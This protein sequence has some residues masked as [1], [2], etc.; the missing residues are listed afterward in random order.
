MN[1]SARRRVCILGGGLGGLATAYYLTNSHDWRDKFE[2]VTVHQ[3]GWRLGGKCA[4]SRNPDACNRIEEHGIHLFGGFY[5]NAFDIMRGVYA[6]L[7]R[8]PGAPLSSID[9]AFLP[10]DSLS[11]WEYVDTAWDQWA[12]L[13]GRNRHKPWDG[14]GAVTPGQLLAGAFRGFIAMALTSLEQVE[15]DILGRFGL[16]VRLQRN[17]EKQAQKIIAHFEAAHSPKDLLPALRRIHRLEAWIE[18]S[19]KGAIDKSE[20]WRRTFIMLDYML[21]LFSGFIADNVWEQGFD[22]L[23]DEDFKDWLKRHG[24]SELTL[25][26]PVPVMTPNVLFAYENGDPSRPPTMGAGGFLHWSFLSFN[27]LGSYAWMFAAGTGETIIAPLY[28]VLKK[29]GV[30]FEFFNKVESISLDNSKTEI[31]SVDIG[32]QATLAPGVKTYDPLTIDPK[33]GLIGWPAKPHYGQLAQ[34]ETLRQRAADGEPVNLESYW[35]DWKPVEQKT[36]VRGED[37]DELVLAISIGAFPYICRELIDASDKWKTMVA[38]LPA[39]QTQSFQIWLRKPMSDLACDVP[40]AADDIFIGSSYVDPT[41]AFADMSRLIEHEGWPE[42]NKPASILYFCGAM[43][44]EADPPPFS[45]HDYPI[46]Q[47]ARVKWQAA[48][49]LQSMASPLIPGGTVHKGHPVLGSKTGLD[50]NLLVCP[51]DPACTTPF[52]RIGQ[53]FFRANVDPTERYVL[54]L[55][56]STRHRLAPGEAGFAYLV[57]AGDWT[58]NGL[59]VG[60][61]EATA[62]S[63]KLAAKALGAQVEDII[64]FNFW[65]SQAAGA[66]QR[67]ADK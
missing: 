34:G 58:N 18:T 27:D 40:T 32:I 2:S 44:E 23:D 12:L 41:S 22:A 20:H 62:I 61:V 66:G 29:R 39:I 1:P 60:C 47:D 42:E 5:Y 31:Q 11:I 28:E 36:L 19:F 53:Q 7:D 16:K 54:S 17:V 38:A 46:R 6:E 45:D 59:N 26:S 9:T 50:F 56:K 43:A 49:F 55:P 30:K 52:A 35:T 10:N 25:S 14:G 4:S 51:I 48:Q 65:T 3:L 57:L 67:T 64:G 37:F 8:P 13:Q 24:A 15:A 63:G 21:T 33:T